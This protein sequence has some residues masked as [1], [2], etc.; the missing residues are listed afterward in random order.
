M[1]IYTHIIYI[2]TYAS[3]STRIS[4]YRYTY[5]NLLS[6]LEKSL[7]VRNR[8]FKQVRCVV[9]DLVLDLVLWLVTTHAHAWCMSSL[10]AYVGA[11]RKY[12][13]HLG[14]IWVPCPNDR[15]SEPASTASTPKRWERKATPPAPRGRTPHWSQRGPLRPTCHC[16]GSATPSRRSKLT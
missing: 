6:V 14:T 12:W 4:I 11:C 9:P 7:K 2:Y 1:N 13:A 10:W 15:P 16:R 8:S 3:I 5:L